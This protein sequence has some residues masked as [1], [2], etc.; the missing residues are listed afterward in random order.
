[1]LKGTIN[2]F[3]NLYL[4]F[5][6]SD[7]SQNIVEEANGKLEVESKKK[8]R[9]KTV[10]NQSLDENDLYELEN[11]TRLLKKLKKRKITE[12]EFEIAVGEDV[13]FQPNIQT[14]N[15]LLKRNR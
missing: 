4:S 2:Y 3:I 6:F 14:S 5:T 7:N 10:Q 9:E 15:P 8:N 11:E 13:N 12:T 1:M